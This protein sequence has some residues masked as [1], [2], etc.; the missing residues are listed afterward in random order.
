MNKLDQM[1]AFVAV[2]DAGSFVA[3]ADAL[4]ISKTAVSRLV[5]ELEARLAVRLIQRTTR[6]QSLTAEGR[7]FLERARELLG[8]IE[9]VEAEVSAHAE[10]AVGH[11]RVN[12][13]VSYGMMIL[14]PLWSR[15]LARHPGVTLEVTLTDR[16]VDLVDEGFDLAIRIGR[17]APS[18]L[19][20]RRL[21]ATRLRL[22]ASPEYLRRHGEPQHPGQL[23]DHATIGYS[24][25]TTG[26]HWHFAGPDGPVAV[27]VR[28][29]MHSNSGDICCTAALEHL[30]IVL[31]PMFLVQAHLESGA[32]RELMPQYRA[33]EFGIHALY[34]SRRHLAS[35]V[36]LLVDFLAQALA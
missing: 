33:P 12:A 22:C 23:A 36:R 28:P 10:Q 15:F 6:R 7:V 29:R 18:S 20:A 35:K 4:G 21:A 9:A 31:E 19:I 5:A 14:A 1:Q 25:L 11:I 17:L 34:P 24:L 32:L 27:K 3:A 16:F 8:A 2:A 13:P 30:G 26:D